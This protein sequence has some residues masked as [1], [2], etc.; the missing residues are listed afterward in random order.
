MYQEAFSGEL[1]GCRMEGMLCEK[2]PV[3]LFPS[4]QRMCMP[5]ALLRGTA[6]CNLKDPRSWTRLCKQNIK[7]D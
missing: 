5:D 2:L 6:L 7:A 4:A 1:Q 3:L